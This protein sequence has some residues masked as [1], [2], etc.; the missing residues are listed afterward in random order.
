MK[1]AIMN[2]FKTLFFFDVA[3][4]A[5]FFLPYKSK[6]TAA[7]TALSKEMV[8]FYVV[9]GLTLLFWLVIERRKLKLFHFKKIF[10]HYSAGLLSGI[11]P[12]AATVLVLWVTRH[13]HFSG[14]T[15]TSHILL[16]LAALFINT[17]ATELLFRGYLLRLYRKYYSFPV[18]AILISAL[19]FSMHYPMLSL[20]NTYV[21]H[22][23]LLNILLCFLEANTGSFV[24][25]LSAHFVYRLI[26]SLAL[27]SLPI[28]AEYPHLFRSSVSGAA[29][30][31]GGEKGLEASVILLIC[32]L[33]LLVWFAR[34]SLKGKKLKL[35]VFVE[36]AIGFIR[37]KRKPKK[38]KRIV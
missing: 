14:R 22:L 10:R 20:G 5:V 29:W 6:S 3:V 15:K 31:T 27:G 32:Q 34:K 26:S 28:S 24:A 19:F 38:R 4:V 1:N 2:L 8:F 7:G 33:A 25:P 37:Q 16:W 12:I 18:A 13:L 21:A 9:A 36:N 17:L 30:M 23:L 35:P 11:I